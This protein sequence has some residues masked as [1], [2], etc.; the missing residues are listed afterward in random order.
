[1][2]EKEKASQQGRSLGSVSIYCVCSTLK[3]Q[4]IRTRIDTYSEHVSQFAFL[5]LRVLTSMTAL[6]IMEH[7]IKQHGIL[8]NQKTQD[9]KGSTRMS[10]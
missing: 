8:C 10:P 9:S 7:L 3:Q 1:M 4:F 2:K 6:D 5:K